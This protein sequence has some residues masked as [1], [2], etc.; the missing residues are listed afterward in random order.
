M[1]HVIVTAPLPRAVQLER[2]A[3]RCC[4]FLPSEGHTPCPAPGTQPD[5][6][7][8]AAP[9]PLVLVVEDDPIIAGLILEILALEGYRVQHVGNGRAA[10]ATVAQTPP[11]VILMDLMLPVMG[12]V[13]AIGVIR[14][15]EQPALARVPI[16]A[17]SAGVNLCAAVVQLPVEGVLAKP[18]NIDE[19]VALVQIQ[20]Q[21][22]AE[23]G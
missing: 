6:P 21:R 23:H 7:E 9:P 4:G 2:H 3:R 11:D 12:G 14:R 8:A 1:P 18:F 20:L 5:T 17:M 16:I 22:A 10:V 15:T 19:L 13:D